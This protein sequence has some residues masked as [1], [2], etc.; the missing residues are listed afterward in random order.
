VHLLERVEV[1]A[2]PN[3]RP[4]A[5]SALRVRHGSIISHTDRQLCVRGRDSEVGFAL[6]S[7][8]LNLGLADVLP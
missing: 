6:G 8:E 4:M 3:D 1:V 2:I 7:Y 5:S